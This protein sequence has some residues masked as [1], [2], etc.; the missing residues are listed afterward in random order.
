MGA[1][2][3][4]LAASRAWEDGGVLYAEVAEAVGGTGMVA[5]G[6]FNLEPHE[7]L[8]GFPGVRSVVI[9]GNIGG[10]M[11]P[12]FRAAHP[13]GSDPLDTW[14]RSVLRPIAAAL[15]ADFVHPSDQP[16]QPFQRWAQR[17]DDV[18]QSPIG[19]LIHAEHGLW[20]AYRGA[21]LFPFALDELPATGSVEQPCLTCRDQPC[22]HTCPVDAFTIDGYDAESCRG[23]VRSGSPPNC[24]DEGCAARC[25]CPVGT[26]GKY[27]SDQ[28]RFHMRAFVGD[29]V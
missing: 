7:R 13:G 2:G 21:L 25:A 6:G 23:H 10:D 28:M 26:D 15:G 4:L 5:R 17:A 22:L 20:H 1:S 16:Y 27:G 3:G 18:W 29:P 24:S 11:W 8:D 9:V 19:L 12:R 14:T